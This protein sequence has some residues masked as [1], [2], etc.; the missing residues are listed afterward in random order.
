METLP[1]RLDWLWFL[2]YTMETPIPDHSVLSKAR[3]RWGEDA[4]KRFFQMIVS[5]CVEAGLVRGDKVFVDSSFIQADASKGSL[6][7][8]LDSAY[9]ELG[10]RLD[11]S[12][13]SRRV[14]STDPDATMVRH[15]DNASLRYKTHRAVDE[16]NE[17]ITAVETTTGIVDDAVKLG[18][19]LDGHSANTGLEAT[20]VA[21]DSKYGTVENFLACHDRKVTAHIKPL[22]DRIVPY[23]KDIF[24]ADRFVYDAVS[25]TFTCPAKKII[26]RRSVIGDWV[27]YTMKPAVCRVCRLRDKCTK[28]KTG[29]TVRRVRHDALTAMYAQGRSRDAKRNLRVR[30]H[31]M[32]RSFAQGVYFG[33]KKARWRRIWRVQIQEYLIASVQ[34]IRILLKAT[35]DR[36]RGIRNEKG[37]IG[38]SCRILAPEASLSLRFLIWVF[39]SWTRLPSAAS[40]A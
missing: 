5:R 38:T 24:P 21:A 36:F 14:S 34:N 33:M 11:G 8:R 39:C 16:A 26:K 7:T 19:L 3:K 4:F 20:T 31:L 23:R 15:G 1:E 35:K 9:D 40:G 32:E 6:V 25:D 30:Q 22:A 12:L 13:N 18:D 28:N 10:K 27:V 17:I 2:D 37:R 29:R